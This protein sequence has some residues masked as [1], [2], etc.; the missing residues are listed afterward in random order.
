M[1]PLAK[2]LLLVST[3][4]ACLPMLGCKKTSGE[5]KAVVEGASKLPGTA[6]VAAAIKK[7]DFDGALQA[8]GKVKEACT[9]EEQNLQ[10][11]VYL[12]QLRQ[13]VVEISMTN[14]AAAPAATALRAMSGTLR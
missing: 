13:Q 11:S 1:K 9:T 6:E 12:G 7:G 4:I 10:F 3:L 14:A 5:D 2:S 8:L